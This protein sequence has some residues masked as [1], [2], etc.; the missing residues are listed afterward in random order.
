MDKENSKRACRIIV[1][2]ETRELVLLLPL[3][4]GVSFTECPVKLIIL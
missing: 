4:I 1:M 2:E 3:P